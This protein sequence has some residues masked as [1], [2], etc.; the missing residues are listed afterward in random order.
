MQKRIIPGINA[1]KYCF[2]DQLDGSYKDNSYYVDK[3]AYI[4]KALFELK[5]IALFTRPRRFGKSMFLSM[6]DSFFS[7]NPKDPS[8]LSSH[9]KIF[10]KLDIYKNTDF[11]QKYMG[12][13]PVLYITF[14]NSG[15]NTGYLSSLNGLAGA[16]ADCANQYLFLAESKYLTESQKA[17]FNDLTQLSDLILPK[18]ILEVKVQSSLNLLCAMLSRHYGEKNVIILVDEYDVPLSK[19]AFTNYYYDFK[20]IMSNMLGCAFKTNTL[21][22]KGF[23][24][25]CLRVAKE[26]IFTGWN[27]FCVVDYDDPTFSSLFGFTDDDV[28]KLLK[29]F[30]FEDKYQTY[31]DWYDGYHFGECDIYCPWDVVS[32][33]AALLKNSQARPKT[34]WN[35]TGNNELAVVAFANDPNTYADEFSELLQGKSIDVPF[36]DDL[37]Y[38]MVES[39]SSKNTPYLWSVLYM[40]GYLTTDKDQSNL[41]EKYIR[42]RIPNKC[43]KECLQ[44]QIDLSFTSK[45]PKYVKKSNEIVECFFNDDFAELQRRLTKAMY[46]YVSIYDTQKGTDKESLYHAFL[47]GTLSATLDVEDQNFYASNYKLGDGRADIVFLLNGCIK[48]FVERPGKFNR[49]LV[50]IECK[51][52]ANHDELEQKAKIAITQIK[53]KYLKGVDGKFP[54]AAVVAMYG[55]AFYKK[56][57]KV[58][59][60]CVQNQTN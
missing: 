16:I 7:P 17:Q 22:A 57:C 52:A 9:E 5:N 40:T 59:F 39:G 42:L 29:N 31:K 10:S 54:D 27:N 49:K 24:T 33:T 8:D 47:N 14:A 3:S 20:T 23:I 26:S 28:L 60:E 45:N 56:E 18:E 25:G 1:F 19:A 35:H 48:D 41:K 4:E 21:L 12:K 38:K 30:G 43:V 51:V 11:C 44:E 15:T 36:F 53:E 6:L 37:N 50:I 2:I 34:Y 32:Y 13:I 58:S 55:I 46:A